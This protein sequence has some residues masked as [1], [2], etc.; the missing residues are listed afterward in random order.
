MMKRLLI[1]GMVL[2]FLSGCAHAISRGVLKEVDREITF[3]ALIKAP[4]AYQGRVVLLGGIIVT[5]I[6]K[7]EGTLLE[8]YQT[9]LDREGRPTNTDRSEGRFLALYQGYL[10]SEI[11]SKGRKVTI[12]GTVQGEKVQLLGEI[13]YRYPY[14]ITKEIH[15]WEKEKPVQ[16]ERYPRDL[17]YDPWDPWG[18][19]GF[20]GW[21]SRRYHWYGHHWHH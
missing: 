20:W 4:N 13:E 1:F 12:A 5:T 7:Q 9:R 3:S 17:W 6:N 15:L 18:P 21:S 11:Y 14:L 16:Y 2:V 19:W 8:V 10:D